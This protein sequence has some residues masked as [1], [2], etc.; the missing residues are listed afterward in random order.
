LPK[1][2]TTNTMETKLY[3]IQLEEKINRYITVENPL[4][5]TYNGIQ[6]RGYRKNGFIYITTNT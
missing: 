3:Y 6:Y 1:L 4:I 2:L 5:F